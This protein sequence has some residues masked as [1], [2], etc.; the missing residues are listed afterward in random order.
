MLNKSIKALM[1]LGVHSIRKA[2]S[3]HPGIVLGA[4]PIIYTLYTKHLKIY[5][6]QFIEYQYPKYCPPIFIRYSHL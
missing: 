3:G 4:S 2:N 1:M 5:P 6:I